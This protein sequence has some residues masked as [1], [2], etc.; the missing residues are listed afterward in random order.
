[1]TA[2]LAKLSSKEDYVN[3]LGVVTDISIIEEVVD[4]LIEEV[5][6][7]SIGHRGDVA[8]SKARLMSIIDSAMARKFDFDVVKPPVDVVVVAFHKD[9]DMDDDGPEYYEYASMVYMD[10]A[11]DV[12]ACDG[13]LFSGASITHW[14]HIP[15]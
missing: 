1:M 9:Y 12:I 11:G 5:H 15:E 6:A 13:S 7:T 2:M 14:M 4:D 3:E 8:G 10:D